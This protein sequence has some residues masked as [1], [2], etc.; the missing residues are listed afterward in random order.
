MSAPKMTLRDWGMLIVLSVL[1]GGSFFL[2][3]VTLKEVTHHA[4][5]FARVFVAAITLGLT[6]LLLRLPFPRRLGFWAGMAL[7]SL[8]SC[9]IPF[10]LLYWAQTHIASGLAAILNAMTPIWTLLIAHLFTRD[11]KIDAQRFAGVLAGL[12]GVTVIVGPSALG[13]VDGNLWAEAAVLGAGLC[14]AI[15]G[16]YGRRFGGYSPV[17]TSF[18]QMAFGSLFLLPVM[19]L[20]G[21]VLHVPLPSSVAIAAVLALGILSTG[22]AYV[23]FFRLLARAGATNTLLVTLLVPVS[24]ILLGVVILGETITPRQFAGLSL[25][26]L[27]LLINDGRPLEYLRSQLARLWQRPDVSGSAGAPMINEPHHSQ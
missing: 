11:E 27:G 2:A 8:V 22:L 6:A 26:A 18:G 23:I 1:W 7:L 15:A 20:A 4:L 25:I 19:L 10:S 24:A 9:A 5:A 3:G 16:V 17:V 13:N 21:P 14:Y 12:A